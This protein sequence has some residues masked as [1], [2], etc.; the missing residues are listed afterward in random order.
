MVI[1]FGW[2]GLTKKIYFS[3]FNKFRS[4]FF[5]DLR[6]CMCDSSVEERKKTMLTQSAANFKFCFFFRFFFA[7]KKSSQ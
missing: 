7:K 6:V 4:N 2:F 3:S 5:F 1:G